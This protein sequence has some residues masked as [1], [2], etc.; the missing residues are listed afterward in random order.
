MDMALEKVREPAEMKET[1]L[2]VAEETVLA[3]RLLKVTAAL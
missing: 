2:V 3:H 1:G